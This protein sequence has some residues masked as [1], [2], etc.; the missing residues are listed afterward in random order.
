MPLQ[1]KLAVGPP[2]VLKVTHPRVLLHLA[3]LVSSA[4][5]RDPVGRKPKR[6]V[7]AVEGLN[8]CEQNLRKEVF[9]ESTLSLIIS[10]LIYF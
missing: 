7:F 4:S 8:K 9:G 3:Y 6:K 5:K 10:L 1:I 2:L